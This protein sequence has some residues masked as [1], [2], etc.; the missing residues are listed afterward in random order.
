VSVYE[1]ERDGVSVCVRG[2][3]INREEGREK[4]RERGREREERGREYVSKNRVE[5]KN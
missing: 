1:I 4:G 5:P 2:S 3:E